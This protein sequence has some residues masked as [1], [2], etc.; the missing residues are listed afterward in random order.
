MS[1]YN[2]DKLKVIFTALARNEIRISYTKTDEILT[3]CSSKIGGRPAVPNDFVWPRFLGESF[4]GKTK[5]RPLSF[6]AQINLEDVKNDDTENL[7]PKTGILSF[8]YEQISMPWGFDP[9]DNGSAKVYYFPTKDHLIPMNIPK[10][11]DEEVIMPELAITFESHISFPEYG[12]LSVEI[13]DMEIE[14]EDYDEC[15]IEYG[16]PCDEYGEVT[17]LLGYSDTIQ[18]SMEEECEIVTRGYRLGFPEDFAVIPDDILEQ[19]KINSKNWILLFQMG[20]IETEDMEYMFG[21]CGHI[22]FWIR[23]QDLKNKNFDRIWL[24]LQCG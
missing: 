20:T 12:D 5:E 3:A 24:I 21:D 6:M 19:V 23:K 18:S 15:R 13:T 1:G 2:K 11:M 4:D 14:W 9:K 7:L 16:Y 17:K 10:D 8:F 22:Y